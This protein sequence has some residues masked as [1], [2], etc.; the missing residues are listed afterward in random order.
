MTYSLMYAF[1]KYVYA[2]TFLCPCAGSLSSL[3]R[4][5]EI[6]GVFP[7]TCEAMSARSAR[8]PTHVTCQVKSAR[9]ARRPTHVTCQ[10]M[11]ALSARRPK[12]VTCQ[13]MSALSV[14][15][16][17]HITCQGMSAL[18]VRRHTHITCQAVPPSF[19][20]ATTVTKIPLDIFVICLCLVPVAL[21]VNMQRGR[22]ARQSTFG[23]QSHSCS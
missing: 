6:L 23:Y 15:R 5:P 18:S 8:R 11:S 12:H 16:H 19:M 10:G 17:T 14:R 9:S 2:R 22:C 1:T 4:T 20:D 13:G 21:V 7:G 3:W